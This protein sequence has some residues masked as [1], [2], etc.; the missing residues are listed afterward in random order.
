MKI[1]LGVLRRIIREAGVNGRFPKQ[2]ARNALSPDINSREAIDAMT[3]KG[4][5]TI[6][7]WDDMPEH[8]REPMLTPE[9]C[10]GPVPPS[11][12]EPYV[13]QDPFARNTSVLPT[14]SIRK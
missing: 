1:K 6:D 9:E 3:S 14:S 12:E 8:L 7:D 4:I 2:P 10:F 13:G 5:D 11:A